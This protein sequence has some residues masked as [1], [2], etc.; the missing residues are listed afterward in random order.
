MVTCLTCPQGAVTRVQRR[1]RSP[2]PVDQRFWWSRVDGRRPPDLLA[3][4]SPAGKL[5]FCPEVLLGLRPDPVLLCPQVS[6]LLPPP[7]QRAPP[8]PPGP[9]PPLQ[10]GVWAG[11]AR[12]Q[13]H[14]SSALPRPG[15][16]PVPAGPSSL[17]WIIW[18]QIQGTN[19]P[20]LLVCV[21]EGLQVQLAGPWEQPSEPAFI[22]KALPCPPCQVPIPT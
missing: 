10:T 7:V 17:Q 4:R 3:A 9:V 20:P 8:V 6:P 12:L 1:C 18:T 16:G 11:A 19:P 15:S 22:K 13:P 21:S 5:S 2:V 14:L